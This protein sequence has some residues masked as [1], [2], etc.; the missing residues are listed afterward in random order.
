[1]GLPQPSNDVLWDLAAVPA[2]IAKRRFLPGADIH[3]R[4]DCRSVF[5]KHQFTSGR[6]IDPVPAIQASFASIRNRTFI[7]P[8][9]LDG[10]W[11]VSGRSAFPIEFDASDLHLG[12]QTV[13]SWP[14]GSSALSLR[15]AHLPAV[16]SASNRQVAALEAG[17]L[18]DQI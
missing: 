14:S 18:S 10:N 8:R 7:Q 4:I 2:R 5:G 12:C 13:E 9:C 17:A 11:A 3:A 16:R 6:Q 1:M 15:L